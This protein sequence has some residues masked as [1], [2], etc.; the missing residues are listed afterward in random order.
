MTKISDH[1]LGEYTIE[2]LT[3]RILKSSVEGFEVHSTYHPSVVGYP[4][5][6]AKTKQM[7]AEAGSPNGFKT[8]P[9]YISDPEINKP[10]ITAHGMLYF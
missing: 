8:K 3:P 9:F 5:N 7:L 4:Y 6:L 1:N 2:F 10:F